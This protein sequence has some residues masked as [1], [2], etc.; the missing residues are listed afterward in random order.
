MKQ[1]SQPATQQLMWARRQSNRLDRILEH[2]PPK[3][4]YRSVLERSPA[5][6]SERLAELHDAAA[7]A[8]EERRSTPVIW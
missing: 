2:L 8:S 1:S 4:C 7:H 5:V 3:A 6:G